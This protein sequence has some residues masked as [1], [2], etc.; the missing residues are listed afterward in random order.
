MEREIQSSTFTKAE[1]EQFKALLAKE[2]AILQHLF[3]DSRLAGI[4]FT[5]GIESFNFEEVLARTTL[6][7]LQNGI[8]APLLVMNED[9]ETITEDIFS[10]EDEALLNNKPLMP[11]MLTPHESDQTGL[12]VLSYGSLTYYHWREIHHR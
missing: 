8:T 5:Q 3:V 6:V 4:R 2:N 7:Q 9:G 12:P 11:F 10:I 1:L